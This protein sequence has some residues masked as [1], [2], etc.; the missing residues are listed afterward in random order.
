MWQISPRPVPCRI[1][2]GPKA[3]PVAKN[4]AKINCF[5]RNLKSVLPN[6]TLSYNF[7]INCNSLSHNFHQKRTPC[8]IIFTLKGHPVEQHIPS[9]Q[10]W[11]YTPWGAAIALVFVHRSSS[12]RVIKNKKNRRNMDGFAMRICM[13]LVPFLYRFSMTWLPLA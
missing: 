1:K 9:S 11:E 13:T 12:G 6:D 3:Y 10:V 2:N 5:K 7:L 4:F 8:C